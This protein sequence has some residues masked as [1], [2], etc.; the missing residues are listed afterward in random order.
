MRWSPN[1]ELLAFIGQMQDNHADLYLYD[2]TTQQLTNLTSSIDFTNDLLNLSDWS[3]DGQWLALVGVWGQNQSNPSLLKGAIISKDGEQFIELDP[4]EPVCR[5]VWS[6]AQQYLFSNTDCPALPADQKATDIVIFPAPFS[7][8]SN[9]P[10]H[11]S[12]AKAQAWRCPHAAW[13]DQSTINL[14][15]SL[16]Q[17]VINGTPAPEFELALYDVNTQQIQGVSDVEQVDLAALAGGIQLGEWIFWTEII[18]GSSVVHAY[19]LSEMKMLN[20][21]LDFP[22]LC[23]AFHIRLSYDEAYAALAAG[24]E[25]TGLNPKTIVWD[26]HNGAS[27]FQIEQEGQITTPLAWVVTPR[28]S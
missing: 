7:E 25:A 19:N 24:C 9:Q 27:L 14:L 17:P 4:S 6:P 18:E 2:T 12:E 11:I 22:D 13:S 10:F 5:L 21:P 1:G 15:R 26:I 16:V 20:I 8:S 28:N 3:P 23:S